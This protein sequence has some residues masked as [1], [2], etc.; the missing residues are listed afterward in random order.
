MKTACI[1]VLVIALASCGTIPGHHDI[2]AL[3][4]DQRPTGPVVKATVFEGGPIIV[5]TRDATQSVFRTLGVV[6]E[7]PCVLG[8]WRSLLGCDVFWPGDTGRRQKGCWI[9]TVGDG[10]WILFRPA[11][12]GR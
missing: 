4:A 12:P 8:E 3:I 1:A 9:G 7:R 10:G 6:E 11:S 5:M 2:P